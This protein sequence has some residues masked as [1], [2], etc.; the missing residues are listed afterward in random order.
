[1]S[2]QTLNV[3]HMEC[4]PGRVCSSLSRQQCVDAAGPIWRAFRKLWDAGIL[5]M[6]VAARNVILDGSGEKTQV[7][8]IDLGHAR[9]S[10]ECTTAMWAQERLNVVELCGEHREA[11]GHL[12]GPKDLM[13]L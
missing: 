3:L 13:L 5:H 8:V 4:A 2:V 1:M 10:C 6:D 9:R 7:K 11:T 12:E